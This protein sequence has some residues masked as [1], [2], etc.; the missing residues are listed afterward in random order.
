MESLEQFNSDVDIDSPAALLIDGA[1]ANP[2]I[3]NKTPIIKEK[4]TANPLLFI[5]KI[6]PRI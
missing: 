5:L 3:K 2:N 6:K 1:R 4:K